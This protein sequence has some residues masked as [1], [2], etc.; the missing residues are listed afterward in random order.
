LLFILIALTLFFVLILIY[1]VLGERSQD[2]MDR[3][4]HWLK[5]HAQTVMVLVFVVFGLYFLIKGLT[6]L[7][8]LI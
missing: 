2:F 1:I 8:G 5:E 7:V 6:G 3:L 4:A